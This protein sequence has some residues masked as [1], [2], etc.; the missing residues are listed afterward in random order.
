MSV[1]QKKT[2]L[3]R[4]LA[5]VHAA[6]DMI[7]AALLGAMMLLAVGQIVLR[8][9]FDTGFLWADPMLRHLVLWVGLL[10]AA[11]ATREDKHI[12]VDVVSRF[13]P[14]RMRAAIRVATDAFAA[15][16]AGLVAYAGTVLIKNEIEFGSKTFLD[17][18]SWTVEIV[19][20]FAFAV[21]SIRYA[22]YAVIHAIEAARPAPAD[23]EPEAGR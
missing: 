11:I 2:G 22:R 12:T 14:P 1:T 8:N 3:A 19:I 6:E 17:L 16:V 7:L 18:P 4:A 13:A 23:A 15:C 10:G 20:P 9:L 21:I 5:F